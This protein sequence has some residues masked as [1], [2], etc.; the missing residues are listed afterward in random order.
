MKN[1]FTSTWFK[2]VSSLLVLCVVLGGTLAVLN[3][4]LSVSANERTARAIKK[5]YGKEVTGIVTL[6]DV[7]DANRSD[8]AIECF[9]NSSENIGTINKI[10]QI[11]NDLLFQST[12]YNGYK[13]GTITLWIKVITNPQGRKLID[14]IVLESNTKQTLMS[15]LDGAYYQNFYID[16]TDNVDFFTSN[17]GATSSNKNVVSGATKSAMAGCNAVNCVIYYLGVK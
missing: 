16:V 2:C 10:Y 12:G 1:F 5:I 13:N 15:K 14:K 11:D 9:N 7:D 8:K 6:L 3:P 17:N 4:L